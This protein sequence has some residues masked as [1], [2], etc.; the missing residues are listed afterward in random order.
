MD[1]RIEPLPPIRTQVVCTNL[2]VIYIIRL[3]GSLNK[4]RELASASKLDSAFGCRLALLLDIALRRPTEEPFVSAHEL[5]GG[6][7]AHMITGRGDV[8][9]LTQHQ[10][11]SRLQPQMFLER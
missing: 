2:F 8:K 4:C 11:R 9:A 10:A 1:R 5:A 7:V 3:A 6:A